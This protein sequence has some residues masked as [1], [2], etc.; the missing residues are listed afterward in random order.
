M[1]PTNAQ[2]LA[3]AA[4]AELRGDLSGAFIARRAATGPACVSES[5]KRLVASWIAAGL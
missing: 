3:F 2:C 5:A 4:R 1:I